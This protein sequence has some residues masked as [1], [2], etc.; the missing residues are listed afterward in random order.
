M[1]KY[2]KAPK[3]AHLAAGLSAKQCF[4]STYKL[5]QC[6]VCFVHVILSVEQDC[7]HTELCIKMLIY[8]G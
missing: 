3:G 6:A 1:Y 2:Q 7:T 8:V 5:C 4:E